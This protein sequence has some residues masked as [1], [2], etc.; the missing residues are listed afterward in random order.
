VP[1]AVS[2]V[3][4]ARRSLRNSVAIGRE[5]CQV[6]SGAD[7]GPG[8]LGAPVGPVEDAQPAFGRPLDPVEAELLAQQAGGAVRLADPDV[9]VRAR[10]GAKRMWLD[11]NTV[12]P[13][14]SASRSSSRRTSMNPAGSS[15]SA[16]SS[17]RR[18]FGRCGRARA[19]EHPGLKPT[20]RRELALHDGRPNSRLAEVRGL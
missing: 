5:A 3:I 8:D 16:G 13:D 1:R 14:S 18:R 20:P 15:P 19:S 6:E 4:L 12:T 2:H 10:S 11:M 7:E 9:E 17:R